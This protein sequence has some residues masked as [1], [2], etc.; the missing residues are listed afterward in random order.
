MA[1]HSAKASRHNTASLRP[2][3]MVCVCHARGC[4]MSLGLI[5]LLLLPGCRLLI[6]PP[7][8]IRPFT[9]CCSDWWCCQRWVVLMSEGIKQPQ[10]PTVVSASAKAVQARPP[11]SAWLG[12]CVLLGG[13]ADSQCT[14]ARPTQPSYTRR[15]AAHFLCVRVC[16][17]P[18]P[19]PTSTPPPPPP[20]LQTPG[21]ATMPT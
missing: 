3:N 13:H 6:I 5:L 16:F 7:P 21:R 8:F 19:T 4:L 12:L 1:L 18:T 14:L 17:N 15:P 9:G 11:R 10:T 2:Q 20:P